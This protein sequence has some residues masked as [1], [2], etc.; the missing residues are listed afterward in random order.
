[1]QRRVPDLVGHPLGVAGPLALQDVVHHP[2]AIVGHGPLQELPHGG[3]AVPVAHAGGDG[4]A[5]GGPPQQRGDE[6]LRAGPHVEVEPVG[7]LQGLQARGL[8]RGGAAGVVVP[9][10]EDVVQLGQHEDA[11]L[12]VGAPRRVGRVRR[13]E[14]GREPGAPQAARDGGAGPRRVDHHA[15]LGPLGEADDP[16]VPGRRGG[17]PPHA[18]LPR[19]E[20]RVRK[21][22]QLGSGMGGL[23]AGAGLEAGGGV[24][25][26][27][28]R[29]AIAL[30]VGGLCGA[31]LQVPAVP[32]VVALPLLPV[33]ARRGPAR[34]PARPAPGRGLLG[35]RARCGLGVRSVILR[36]F[37]LPRLPPPLHRELRVRGEGAREPRAD[38]G[39]VGVHQVRALGDLEL[40][41]EGVLQLAEEASS[42]PQRHT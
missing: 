41:A 17:V 40:A 36:L 29:A 33:P 5:E 13:V 35:L 39:A 21:H 30:C 23:E 19:R 24:L 14:V 15:L 3:Q 2:L 1:M 7:H 25:R 12:R 38:G 4:E 6:I 22:V 9:P 26:A 10:N 18:A 42:L 16:R 8:S 31:L 27:T 32:R 28:P 20:G 34:V 37:G 11:L